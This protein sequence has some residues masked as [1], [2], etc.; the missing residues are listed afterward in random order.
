MQTPPR[1]MSPTG[2]RKADS[3]AATGTGRPQ[4]GRNEK[5]RLSLTFLKRTSVQDQHKRAGTNG[6]IDARVAGAVGPHHQREVE[7]EFDRPGTRDSETGA[8]GRGGTL[9]SVKKRLS[10]LGM[11]HAGQKKKVGAVGVLEEDGEE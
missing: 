9:G 4:S 1:T 10:L 11:G 5:H 7:E 6:S 2:P 8:K 3:P